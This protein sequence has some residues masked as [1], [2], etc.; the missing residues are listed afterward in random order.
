LS[1]EKVLRGQLVRGSIH[2]SSPSAYRAKE[3]KALIMVKEKYIS[4]LSTIREYQSIEKVLFTAE[5]F[6]ITPAGKFITF[7]Y[8]IPEKAPYTFG[9]MPVKVDWGVYVSVKKSRF[10][11]ENTR[12]KFVVL[13][14]VL[15]TGRLPSIESIPMPAYET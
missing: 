10:S 9:V 8:S 5:N 4:T 15:K 14:H 3:V 1:E 11:S 6:E 12:Q 2:I 13:P 7:K